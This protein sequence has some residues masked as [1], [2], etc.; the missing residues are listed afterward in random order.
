MG[1]HGCNRT[2]LCGSEAA[3]VQ[4]WG[5]G[6]R[7]GA[8]VPSGGGADGVLGRRV[9]AAGAV[10]EH[11]TAARAAAAI[12]GDP[13][14]QALKCRM[15]RLCMVASNVTGPPNAKPFHGEHK[16]ATCM[17]HV[18]AISLHNLPT[19]NPD[20]AAYRNVPGASRVLK[21]GGARLSCAGV[22]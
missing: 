21:P 11:V 22:P 18:Q 2:H 4:E 7:T 8:G 9:A 14:A 19:R 6:T 20:H 12:H 13:T 1:A 5:G 15:P 10:V 3:V 17:Q 16:A